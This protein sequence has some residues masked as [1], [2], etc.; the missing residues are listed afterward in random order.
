MKFR[1]TLI[2]ALAVVSLVGVA[3]P[4]PADTY[5]V[6]AAGEP[7]SFRW[8]PSFRHVSK[9]DKI[10]W[11]N[12]TSVT[13]TV[14]AYSGPWS[15]DSSV[16]PGGRTAFRFTKRGTYRYRCTTAGHSTLT[17]GECNGMCGEIHVM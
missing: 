3:A 5:R 2:S 8:K 10:V 12:P 7:G 4:A 9:G 11:K 13:H 1:R 16:S 15:K 14:T 6:R 17:G